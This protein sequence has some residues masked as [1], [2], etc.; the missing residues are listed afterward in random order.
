MSC[1]NTSQIYVTSVSEDASFSNSINELS[2]QSNVQDNHSDIAKPADSSDDVAGSASTSTQ[3]AKVNSSDDVADSASTST[4][5]AKDEEEEEE[6]EK[7]EENKEKVEEVE[8]EIEDG[9]RKEMHFELLSE[10]IACTEEKSATY[11]SLDCIKHLPEG[12]FSHCIDEPFTLNDNEPA[13]HSVSISCIDGDPVL[14]VPSCSSESSGYVSHFT[15]NSGKQ[16]C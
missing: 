7:D 15:W 12:N 3:T 6:E 16:L 2:E 11:E 4:Q 10:H 8:D 14:C 5:T 1:E 9:R 13:A